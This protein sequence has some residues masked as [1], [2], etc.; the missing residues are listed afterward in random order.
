M[1]WISKSLIRNALSFT[2]AGQVMEYSTR[3]SYCEVLLSMDGGSI[4][5]DEN[6]AGVYILEEKIERG[7]SR[8]NIKK[9]DARYKDVSFMIARDKIKSEDTIIE[10]DWSVFANDII[11][12]DDG[13]IRLQ[14]MLK[15]VYPVSKMTDEYLSRIL[16]Y[17]NRFEYALNSDSFDKPGGGYRDFIDTESFNY[18]AMINEITKNVDGCVASVYFY[19]DVGGKLKAGPVWDHDLS[20]GNDVIAKNEW[21]DPIGFCMVETTWFS[22][23]FQDKNF[24]ANYERA[25]KRLRNTIWSGERIDTLIDDLVFKLGPAAQRNTERWYSDPDIYPDYDFRREVDDIKR[26]LRLRMEWMDRNIRL[27]YRMPERS[28]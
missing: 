2:M 20:L 28:A 25:Y 9:A 13:K 21:K 23:L 15:S 22:R 26:F 4:S 27:V 1:K 6:Y 3:F 11:L 17:F 16:D 14:T 8:V 12:G 18:Y 24:S 7:E 19:K 5:F 10:T